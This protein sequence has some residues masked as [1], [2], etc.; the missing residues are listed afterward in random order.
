MSPKKKP[1]P[2]SELRDFLEEKTALYN[3][4]SFIKDDPVLI[5]R[6]FS[7]KEDIEISGFLSA[8]IAWGQR[9]VIIRNAKGWME[10]MDQAPFDFVMQASAKELSSL[11]EFVHRTFN[12]TDARFFILA[13]RNIYRRHQSPESVFAQ[14]LEKNSSMQEAISHFR[15]IFL[16]VKHEQRS[17]KHIANPASG[18]NAKRINM[19]LRWM[20]RRDKA[21][22]DFGIW[23]SISP[24]LLCCPLDVH[25]GNVARALGLLARRQDDWRAVEELTAKL[26]EF[27]SAD[28]VKYDFALFGLGIYEGFR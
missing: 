16:S 22:V 18:S 2:F 14:G 26:R 15:K 20:V 27:D 7:R 5:P 9:P 12:G 28:P 10:R 25:T 11:D 1:L 19:F 3:R 4:P 23:K 24:S 8:T 17:E 21:G 6:M 13:L